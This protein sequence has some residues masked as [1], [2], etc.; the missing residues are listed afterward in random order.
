MEKSEII[1]LYKS[2]RSISW[3][4]KE[5]GL[6]YCRIQKY[7]SEAGISI[8]GGRSKKT[9][10]EDELIYAI[11]LFNERKN[12][13]EIAEHFS[14]CKEVIKR[15]LINAGIYDPKKLKQKI[16][17]NI[18]HDY[19]KVIDDPNK[20]YWLGLLFTDGQVDNYR[21]KRI[22]LSLQ[23]RDKDLLMKFKEDL[24]VSAN[25]YEDKRGAGCLQV[26]FFS[27]QIF[28]DLA[29]YGIIPQKTYKTKNIPLSLIPKQF[30]RDFLRGM[31]DGDGS[32]TWYNS[33][34]QNSCID[35]CSY[36]ET[37]IDDFQYAIDSFIHKENHTK[38]VYLG[39]W[40]CRW[41]GRQQCISILDF[42]YEN[43]E[44]FIQRKY[45]KYMLIK[46]G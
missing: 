33:L 24:G 7:L 1:E 42:L 45:D 41:K 44:R 18:K 34:V 13:N 10:S 2:G 12:L 40:H 27:D 5:T 35:F 31:L 37:I 8:R 28:D 23:T 4:K 36:Q 21:G 30:Q 22:R 38:K 39:C 25:L 46:Q 26:E 17:F 14:V 43:A 6:P 9:L 19:F 32:I 11:R 29:K 3:I 20:A 15:E 16:N